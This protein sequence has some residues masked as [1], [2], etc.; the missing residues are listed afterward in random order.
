LT[1]VT[2]AAVSVV[3]PAYNAGAFLR[4]AVESVLAQHEWDCEVIVVDDGSTDDTAAVAQTFEQVR[5]LRRPNGGIG[6]A[7]NTGV[8]QASAPLLA[9]LDADD[10]WPPGR[11]SSLAEGLGDADAVFGQAV[12]FG[13]GR[14]ETAPQPALLASTMLIRRE[15]QEG[16]GPFK[17]D[18]KVGEF[19]DWWARAEELGLR[20]TQVP[21]VVLRRRIHTS[22]TGIVQAGSRV[23][24]TRVLRAALERRRGA[25]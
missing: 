10:I 25:S 24:Y 16:V 7:R 17:E 1:R 18:V 15:A 9:F 20:W 22:N 14:P 6:A 2:Q 23:D 11:L 8:Q 3:I 13:E 19:V 12:E 21:A 5:L 4:D